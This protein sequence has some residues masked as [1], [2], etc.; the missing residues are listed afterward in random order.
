MFDQLFEGMRKASESSQRAQQEMLKQWAQQWP[1]ASLNAAGSSVE[2]SSTL[3]RKWVEAVTET[4][5]RQRE[6]LDASCR[7]GL[8]LLEQSAH[9]VEAKSPDDARHVLEGV[10]R[11]VF[12]TLKTQS[13][14]QLQEL[15][16]ASQAWLETAQA[17]LDKTPA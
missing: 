16:K 9:V 11:K 1:S 10:W 14:V 5:N 12:E 2:W 15:R 17:P 4:L 3:Q 13:D 6:A 8:S 7:T